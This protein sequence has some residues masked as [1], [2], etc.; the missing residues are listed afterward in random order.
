MS[1]YN[2]AAFE[3]AIEIYLTEHEGY[4][5][6]PHISFNRELCL[7]TEVF[8]EFVK[9]TQSKEYD[10]L[11][12]IHKDGTANILIEDLVRALNSE[13]EGTLNVL[14]HGF[15][16]FGRMIHA[17]YFAPASTMNPETQS[18]YKANILTITR[19]ARYSP[20][21][22]NSVDIVLA[23]NGIPVITIEL[24]NPLTNQTW[25]NAIH[26]YKHDRDPND[27]LFAFKKRALVHFA[28]DTDQAYMTTRLLGTHTYFLPFNKGR[29]NGKGNPDNP[30]GYKTAYLWEEV[31][32]RDSIMD[33]LARFMHLQVVEV[34]SGDKTLK[35][36]TMI[37]PR[38]HQLRCV[39]RLIESTSNEGAGGNYL[40]QHSAG[41]GK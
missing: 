12:K 2:E 32:A 24:K 40:V 3:S 17:A 18:L 14:R 26:Q 27:L 37:F 34:K 22:E 7:D 4:K 41:S 29:D 28:V 15:K 36:E 31:L 35:K 21:H 20:K 8:I 6:R 19:Q 1:H 23:L 25:M 39:R 11:N 38:Y 33:I 30:N 16:S 9:A 5:T 10:Y 13:H